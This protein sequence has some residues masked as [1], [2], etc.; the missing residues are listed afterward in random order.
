MVKIV[1]AGSILRVKIL[2]DNQV[3]EIHISNGIYDK[4][5]YRDIVITDGKIFLYGDELKVLANKY[6]GLVIEFMSPLDVLAEYFKNYAIYIEGVNAIP[7]GK[8]R[9]ALSL[10]MDKFLATE[11]KIE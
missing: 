2:K 11:A 10:L 7:E 1:L 8:E 3:K 5:I 4:K 6:D 9:E